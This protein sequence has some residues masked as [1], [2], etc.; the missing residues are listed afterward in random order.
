MQ[1]NSLIKICIS[2][3][4]LVSVA[5]LILL[6]PL[7]W[8]IAWF[9]AAAFHEIFH[10]IALLICGHAIDSL[11]LDING[12]KIQTA[13]LTNVETI[14]CALS[15]P[16]G[17]LLLLSFSQQYPQLALCALIQSSYNL[18]PIYPLDGGRAFLAVLNLLFPKNIATTIFK[19][20]ELSVYIL[21][22]LLSFFFARLL[23][24][25]FPLLIPG[26]LFLKH[27]GK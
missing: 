24:T 10:C 25:L 5:V 11:H 19:I 1:N 14:V 13:S 16:I 3:R 4:F 9:L 26:L 2:P 15:G 23:K 27:R 7:N 8:L 12:A 20:A 18:L 21:L 22:F 6:V 17:G